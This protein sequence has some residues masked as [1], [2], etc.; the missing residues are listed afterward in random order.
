MFANDPFIDD[1]M[2][3]VVVLWMFGGWSKKSAWSAIYNPTCKPNSI[4]PQ[5]SN[6]FAL[7]EVKEIVELFRN[8]FH[9][10]NYINPK[11]WERK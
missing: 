6:F 9:E 1:S 5:V 10:N 2:R 7:K 11:A 3:M 8:Y 4:A